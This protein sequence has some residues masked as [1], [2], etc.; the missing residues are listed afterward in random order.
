VYIAKEGDYRMSHH[1]EWDDES[2]HSA[3][4]RHPGLCQPIVEMDLV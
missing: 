4:E 2:S 3:T 1:D